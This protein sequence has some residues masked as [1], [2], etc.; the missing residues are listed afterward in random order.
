VRDV[1]T[2]GVLNLSGDKVN[3]AVVGFGKMGMLHAGILNVLPGVRLVALCERSSLIRKFLKKLFKGIHVVDDVEKLSDFGLDAVYVTTPIPSHFSVVKN[4]YGLGISCNLFVEKTLASSFGEA[5]E[6]CD[7]T[8]KFGGVNMVG[9]MR[10]F[11]VTFRKAK[12]LLNQKVIGE[13]VSF[14]AYAYSSDFFGIDENSK[15]H[16][17]KIG[18]LRDLGCH[19]IDLAVWLFGDFEVNNAKIESLF[20]EGSEDSAFF[21]VETQSGVSGKFNVSW[22]V[23]KHRM[24][25]VGFTVEGSKGVMR[26]NDDELELGLSSGEKFKWFRHDLKDDV[27]FWLGAP[28]YYR[29]DE[30]FVKSILDGKNVEPSFFS[31][32]KVDLVIDEVRAKAKRK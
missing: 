1:C 13:P 30:C 9:Y 7:L 8:H 22:C 5:N 17:P 14:S 23:D 19:A 24:P 31:S 29:E 18:V 3:A 21:K 4:I 15:V 25:E 10:R 20:G 2:I 27:G 26:V 28:E 11:S 6:L 12:D 16:T 32:A